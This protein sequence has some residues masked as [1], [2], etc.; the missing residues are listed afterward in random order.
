V[1][2]TGFVTAAAV[3]ASLIAAPPAFAA[4]PAPK[5]VTV[6]SREVPDGK[7]AFEVDTVK[8][9][10]TAGYTFGINPKKYGKKFTMR[11]RVY[12]RAG[13]VRYTPVRTYQ[14]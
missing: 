4:G 2:H 7:R 8:T 6:D 5:A 14:R 1:K 9:D 3:A 13:N 10:T 12:D 11:F